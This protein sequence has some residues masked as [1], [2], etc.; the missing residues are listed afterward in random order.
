MSIEGY[1]YYIHFVDDYT[2]FTWIFPLKTKSEAY[3]KVV[4]F[5]TFVER[6]FAHKIKCLQTN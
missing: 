2:R 3:S 6:Q 4:H 5:Q 1:K